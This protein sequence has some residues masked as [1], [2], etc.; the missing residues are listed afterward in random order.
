[1][2][3]DDNLQGIKRLFEKQ[4][5]EGESSKEATGEDARKDVSKEAGNEVTAVERAKIYLANRRR[6]EEREKDRL[7]SLINCD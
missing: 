7:R 2:E 4:N 3:C 6:E 1:M 5:K